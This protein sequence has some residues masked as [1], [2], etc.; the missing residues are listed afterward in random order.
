[1]SKNSLTNKVVLVTGAAHRVG[2]AIVRHLHAKGARIVLHYRRS[3]DAAQKLSDE[4]CALRPESCICLSADLDNFAEYESLIDRAV[5]HWGQLDVL[6]NNA[7][8]FFPTPIGFVDLDQWDALMNSNVRA[9][10]FL[11]Q[12]AAAALR[13]SGGC[14]VNLV[15][16]H[17]DRPLKDYPVYSMAKAALVMM[18]KS[19]ARELGPD[20]RVNAVAPGAILWPEEMGV[21]VQGDIL[22]RT[23]LKRSGEPLDIAR[24]VSYLVQEATYT[25]GQVL[26]V[27]GGRN[28]AQ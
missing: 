27:D 22:D 23:A 19:L 12:Q 24:A 7:S 5:S 6:V 2:A 1:M 10:F 18:T 20:I 9:P 15:D 16:I 13:S 8:A 21:E 17:A 25:T 28:L 4:L 11:S 14:I 3:A 26:V